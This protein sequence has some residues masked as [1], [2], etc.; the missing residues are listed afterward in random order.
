MTL[1]PQRHQFIL[2]LLKRQGIVK[3]QELVHLTGASESTIRR[4]LDQLQQQHL[5]K[6]VHGGAAL[7]QNKGLEMPIQEKAIRHTRE[8]KEIA[9]F[10]GSFVDQG[11]CIYL[12][13]GSTTL[14]MIP[15][16]AGK[17]VTVVTNGMT[18]LE[19]LVEYDIEAYVLGGKMKP[20]TKAL[21]GAMALEGIERYRF[22]QCFL[23]TN[24]IH[25]DFGYTTPDPEEAC[26]KQKALQL[27][28]QAFVLADPSKLSEVSF[29]KFAD[30]EEASLITLPLSSEI[31]EKLA[32]KTY[33]F[34][35]DQA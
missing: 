20:S 25:P 18:H 30:L 24:G 11:A 35:V 9:L 32:Q 23:G 29:A 17:Q 13:A 8:K 15:P 10:A 5:L 22:D 1:T 19:R 16:L 34:E 4:D 31:K 7:L 33:V 12:D 3:V 2:S 6:R 14:E 27:S 26:L 28:S 21:I